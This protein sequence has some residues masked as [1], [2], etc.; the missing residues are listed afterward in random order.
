MVCSKASSKRL[1]NF[2][3]KLFPGKTENREKR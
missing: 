2:E 1:E 3:R